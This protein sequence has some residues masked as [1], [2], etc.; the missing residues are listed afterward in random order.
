M[1]D[2]ANLEPKISLAW[3]IL[4]FAHG[5]AF[6]GAFGMTRSLVGPRNA[7][8]VA[9]IKALGN[10][11]SGADTRERV[12]TDGSCRRCMHSPGHTPL[13]LPRLGALVDFDGYIVS[14]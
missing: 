12:L 11:R 1:S 2:M 6:C 9:L 10:G 4:R 7:N 13:S 5:T 8:S 14:V 3:C